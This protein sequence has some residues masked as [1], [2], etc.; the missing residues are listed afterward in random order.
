MRNICV[1]AL[2][3]LVSCATGPQAITESVE[4]SGGLIAGVPGSDPSVTVFKGVPYAAPPVGDLRWKAP[5]PPAAWEGVRQADKFS[6]SCV[7]NIV[8]ERDP[9]THEFM[10]HDEIS[11]DCLYLNIWTAAEHADEN[12]PVFVY[13]HGGGFTEGSGSVAVYDG[14]G[15]ANKGLVMVTINYRLGPFGF[16]AHPELTKESEYGASGN[17]G[18][19]DVVAAL[20]WIQDNIAAFGGDPSRVTVAGQ[21][22]GARAVH[23]LIASPLA[24]GLIHRGI[25]ESGSSLGGSSATLADAEQV[26]VQFAELKGASSLAELRAMSAEEIAAPLP[27][28]A[29]GGEAE[30]PRL[31]FGTNVDGYLLPASI[32]EIA[33][34]GSQNDVPIITGANADEGGAS[35][36]LEITLAEYRN[37]ARQRY[38]DRAETFLT[39]YP[40]ST[41]QEAGQ[42]NNEASRDRQRVSLSVWAHERKK[43]TESGIHTYFWT[44]ALPGPD[45]ARYGAFHTSEVPYALNTLYMSDRPFTDIDHQIADTMSSYWANFAKTGDP[46]GEGLPHWPAVREDPG[47]TMQIGDETKPIPLAGSEGKL[48]F[49]REVVLAPRPAQPLT[50]PM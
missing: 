22:A 40:A 19:L 41:D 43:T 25:A 1:L 44:H 42:A 48:E 30:A 8:E 33:A 12:R 36:N 9:W 47:S 15:L 4:T 31:R 38:G 28:P 17:Y 27:A 3:A 2:L 6:G 20:Q 49:W 11:E 34:Q 10:S 13:I 14:D 26:G 23:T 46:N 45:A 24:T 16:L 50:G 32:D 5:Q 7:Q 35:P 18:M 39:L 29:E 37:Q 21:S